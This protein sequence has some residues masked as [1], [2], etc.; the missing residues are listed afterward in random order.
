MRELHGIGVGRGIALGSVRR[1]PDPISEPDDATR[2]VDAETEQRAV[3]V[4]LA[5]VAAELT[6]RGEQAGGSAKD[7]L[8]A[9]A[10]MAQDPSIV[11]DVNSRIAGGSTGERAVF[12]AFVA[13]QEILTD[14]GGY[15]GERAADLADVAQR[16]IAT[17]RGVPA[18]GVPTSDKPFVLVANDLAPAD[19]ALLDLDKVI[20]L[21]TRDGGP[22]SHTACTRSPT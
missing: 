8:D 3:A 18:P 9:Q 22:T 20:A 11:D 13:F 15:M 6:S 7:V 19:T 2:T 10:M 4:A 1:M 5:T 21:V 16:V 17:L 14:M 12:E